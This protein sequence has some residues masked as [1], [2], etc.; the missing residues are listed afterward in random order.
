MTGPINGLDK[1]V[2][3]MWF[4]Q[5]ARIHREAAVWVELDGTATFGMQAGDSDAHSIPRFGSH[6]VFQIVSGRYMPLHRGL[7]GTVVTWCYPVQLTIS[8]F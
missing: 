6:R 3:I 2:F 5:I 1:I 7:G 8:F 4:I